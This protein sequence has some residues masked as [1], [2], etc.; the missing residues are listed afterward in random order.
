MNSLKADVVSIRSFQGEISEQV[1]DVQRVVLELGKQLVAM[2]I[3]LHT[4]QPYGSRNAEKQPITEETEQ[5][6]SPTL[7]QEH[8]EDSCGGV[9]SRPMSR[10]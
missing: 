2:S 6:G 1:G 10:K 9:I 3:I 4:L 5:I 8:R 7:Q